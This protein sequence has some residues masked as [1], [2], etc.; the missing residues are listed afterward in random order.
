MVV[1]GINCN[2]QSAA[3]VD[4]ELPSVTPIKRSRVLMSS[5]TSPSSTNTRQTATSRPGSARIKEKLA[6]KTA[7]NKP[8]LPSSAVG[9]MVAIA[10]SPAHQQ[11]FRSINIPNNAVANALNSSASVAI[12]PSINRETLA[13]VLSSAVTSP[14]C[15]K[16]APSNSSSSLNGA[17]SE[18]GLR[19]F[20]AMVC[21]KVE[22]KGITSYNEVNSNGVNHRWLTNW[23]RNWELKVVRGNDLTTKILEDGSMMLSMS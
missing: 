13:G 4:E 20:S 11:I 12:M 8:I 15:A 21:S 16:T 7:S 22:E 1:N 10:P 18:K 14:A 6:A 5:G 2:E 9:G 19:Q 23:F 17:K 3:L